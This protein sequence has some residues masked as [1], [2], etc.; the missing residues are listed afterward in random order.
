MVCVRGLP[1][2][3]CFSFIFSPCPICLLSEISFIIFDATCSVPSS[4]HR[5]SCAKFFFLRF[6]ATGVMNPWPYLLLETDS[7]WTLLFLFNIFLFIL[8]RS[9]WLYLNILYYCAVVSLP[10]DTFCSSSWTY[11]APTG[12]CFLPSR[13][14]DGLQPKLVPFFSYSSLYHP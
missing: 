5:A 8:L 11:V 10:T 6:S 12:V 9:C 2:F 1:P 3:S 7:T 4:S 13:D 14:L